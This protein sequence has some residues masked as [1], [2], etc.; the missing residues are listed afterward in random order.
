M[1]RWA[2]ASA[3][4][5]SNTWTEAPGSIWRI[6]RAATAIF[7]YLAATSVCTAPTSRFMLESVTTSKSMRAKE[8]TPR[9]ASCCATCEPR[10][11]SPTMAT[12][13]AASL[14]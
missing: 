3:M 14:A 4:R 10:P 6:V 13:V 8:R 1:R 7:L 12:F 2:S 5:P 11:P 9:W